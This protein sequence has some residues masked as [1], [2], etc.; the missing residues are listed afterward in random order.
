GTR[1]M[2]ESVLVGVNV[3]FLEDDAVINLDM[4]DVLEAMGCNVTSCLTMSQAWEA[5]G[6]SSPD[7]AI[8][9]V[10]VHDTTSLA[11]ADSLAAHG[12]PILFLTGYDVPALAGKWR[13]HPV[14]RKPCDS[15]QLEQL[16]V[17][18]LAAT[19]RSGREM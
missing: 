2:A 5:L 12:I 11:L 17:E 7:I 13:N 9:D 3:L 8:L 6:S 1:R 18:A 10:T 4:A 15:I 16:L 14:C 19:R